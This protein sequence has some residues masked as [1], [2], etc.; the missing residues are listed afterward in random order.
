M[1][2]YNNKTIRFISNFTRI[3]AVGYMLQHDDEATREHNYFSVLTIHLS[4]DSK[5]DILVNLIEYFQ[6]LAANW[7]NVFFVSAGF[8]LV[9]N[10]II[11]DIWNGHIQSFN[12]PKIT[13]TAHP[14]H[15][16]SLHSL[17]HLF[18]LSYNL[19]YYS[20]L[21]QHWVTTHWPPD[22]QHPRHPIMDCNK[23][24]I[25]LQF[26]NNYNEFVYF[27]FLFKFEHFW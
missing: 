11:R 25:K 9:G 21:R 16:T 4:L 5:Y 1:I 8:Y 3:T 6:I 18:Q 22:Q 2:N 20:R 13:S 27:N 10:L 7:R 14:A 12:E 24:W 15:N 26:L 23:Y 19:I 17:F